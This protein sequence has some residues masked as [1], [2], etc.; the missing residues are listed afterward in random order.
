[1]VRELEVA[2]EAVKLGPEDSID[3]L[4]LSGESAE[5]ARE[6]LREAIPAANS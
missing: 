5:A 4:V 6:E 3:H 1:V 2:A